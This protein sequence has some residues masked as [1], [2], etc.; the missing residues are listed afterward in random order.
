MGRSAGFPYSV[1]YTF[2]SLVAQCHLLAIIWKC[3][4]DAESLKEKL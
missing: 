2:Q 3:L 4:L 1:E